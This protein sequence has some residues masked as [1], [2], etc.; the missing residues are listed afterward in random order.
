MA[1]A[2]INSGELRAELMRLV[3]SEER[4]AS[5]EAIKRMVLGEGA[6]DANL[7]EFEV[8]LACLQF[9]EKYKEAGV[10]VDALAEKY[11]VSGMMAAGNSALSIGAQCARQKRAA[12]LMPTQFEG[13]MSF[14]GRGWRDPAED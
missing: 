12:R 6:V 10:S 14:T 1:K 4:N 7:D 2:G 13:F 11:G 8:A 3:P 5:R 9:R